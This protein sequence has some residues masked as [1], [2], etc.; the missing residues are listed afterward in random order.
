MNDCKKHHGLDNQPNR[1][2]L[3]HIMKKLPGNQSGVGRHKCPYCAYEKGLK[4]GKEN[5]TQR[6]FFGK[7]CRLI[8]PTS[9]RTQP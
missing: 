9:P 8:C 3:D 7:I 2:E 6:T 5:N 1:V 4:A